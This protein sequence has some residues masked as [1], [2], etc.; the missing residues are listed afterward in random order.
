MNELKKAMKF[1]NESYYMASEKVIHI[2]ME[3]TFYCDNKEALSSS[4]TM[5]KS[6]QVGF[7]LENLKNTVLD[8]NGATL[9]FHGRIVPF[10]L[11]NCENVIIKNL[12]IDYDRPFYT[13]ADVLSISDGKMEIRIDDDFDFEIKDGYL[14]AKSETWEKNLNRN[15]CLLWLYDKSLTK[16]Y[17]IILGLFGDEIFPAENPP[18]PIRQ[19]KIEDHGKK[20]VIYGDFPES[21]DYNAGNNVLLITHEV[22]DKNT[23]TF[24]GGS[25]IIIESCIL[26]HG[27][28]MGVTA[29][30]THNIVLDNYSMYNNYEGNG[31]MVTNNADAVHCFNCSGK[32]E[33]KNCHMEGLLDDTVNIHCNYFSVKEINGNNLTMY[34]KSCEYLPHS[35]WFCKDDIIRVYKGRTLEKVAELKIT[36]IKIDEENKIQYFTVDGDTSNISVDDTVENMSAQPEVYIHDC[37]FGEFRGTMR[38]QSRS[39]TIVEDC[40]FSNKETSLLFSGD[41][42]YWYESGPVN[43]MIIRRCK[44]SGNN[45]NPRLNFFGEVDFTDSEKYYHQNILVEDCEF[46]DCPNIATLRHVDGFVLKNNC[47]EEGS[48]ITLTQCGNVEANDSVLIKKCD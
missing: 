12:K 11:I 9:I 39:K 6:C 5:G 31:R 26:I 4:G 17:D 10:I 38:L 21:W 1:S 18:L 40:V 30:H 36:D 48:Y 7:L 24:V 2:F 13:Q 35:I 27:A 41:T 20:Q 46:S 32:I 23:F 29:M 28:A 44:F 25:D 14:Y 34:S 33:I 15:D 19:L 43:D 22:R 37:V 45:G 47:T 3:D 8:F 42:T 16:S